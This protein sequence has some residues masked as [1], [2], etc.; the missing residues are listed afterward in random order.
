MVTFEAHN[1]SQMTTPPSHDADA[2]PQDLISVVLTTYRRPAFLAR[3]LT[4][5]LA[6]TYR[7]W[8]LIV[9]DDN[10]PHSE[11]R[12]ETEA[13]VER[14]L[15]D[16]RVRYLKHDANRGGSAARNSGIR[17]ARGDLVAFL[18]DD[19]E[20]LPG[21]LAAQKIKM[22][23]CDSEVALVYTSFKVVDDAGVFKAS[24]VA[25]KR[26]W[27]YPAIVATNLIGTT[28][29]I[30]C[31]KAALLDVGLFDESLPGAQDRDLYIRLCQRYRVDYVSAPLVVFH[32]HDA[33]RITKNRSGKLKAQRLLECKYRE[34]LDQHPDVYST[35]LCASG[36]L[37]MR[38][39]NVSDAHSMFGHAWRRSPLN[40]EAFAYWTL[41]GFGKERF[42]AIKESS[43]SF[44][45]RFLRRR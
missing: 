28:S 32:N 35:F 3:A 24:R 33:G 20:W 13:L 11:S 14:F 22:D 36:K 23:R 15:E 19:D 18:D 38:A 7:N 29:S 42:E 37:L 26:G 4:C 45:K 40:L 21:K 2:H 44:R 17:A 1:G 43:Q 6:Q 31:R 8:E 16:P 25:R 27:L 10:D 30:L 12:R 41:S 34:V 39:G 9:V 5:V